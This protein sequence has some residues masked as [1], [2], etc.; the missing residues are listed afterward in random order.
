MH[1]A[2]F[3]PPSRCGLDP[4]RTRRF[5]SGLLRFARN[6][7]NEASPESALMPNTVHIVGAGL[8]GLSAAVRLAQNGSRVALY[9]AAGQAGGRCRSYFD[10]GFGAMIDNG[11]HLLLSGNSAA[12][13]YARLIGGADKLLGPSKAEFSFADLATGERWTLSVNE[14]RWPAWLFD[15]S[16]RVPG[17]KPSDYVGAVPL[18]WAGRSKTVTDVLASQ[19]PLYTK[20]W[21]PLMLAALNTDPHEGSAHLAGAIMRNTLAKGGAACRP[22]VAEG[23]SAVFVDPGL[24]YIENHAGAI[25][26][27]A[28][29]RAIGFDDGRVASLDF[30]NERPPVGENDAV[31]LAVPPWVAEG[32]VPGLKAPQ[33]FRAI[34][35]A[36]YRV[37]PPAGFPR[38]LGLVNG[39][40]EWIFAF[41]G[42]LSITISGAD[43]L[44]DRPREQLAAELWREVASVTGLSEDLPAWQ[45][46]KEKRATFAATPEQDA[47]RPDTRTRWRNLFLA[48]DWTQ[49][50][51]PATI[52]GA[53]R[54]GERAAQW[55]MKGQER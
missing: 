10:Q 54:S 30:G 17:T 47:L 22:L 23:L 43:R 16:R 32:L 20:L 44:V 7:D 37:E 33:A 41:P 26:F 28:R 9:E 52:E 46:V 50:G 45:I 8:A 15:P 4:E 27:N 38:I 12:L 55:A 39:T 53:I 19:G 13:G 51:L 2:C 24:R 31:I 14:G 18:L 11:N 25:T 40:V 35:N 3:R 29:V 36:H 42:R 21:H 5:T 1:S 48:G 6:G 34:V 49:T